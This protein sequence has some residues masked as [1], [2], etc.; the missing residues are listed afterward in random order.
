MHASACRRWS[1]VNRST[2]QYYIVSFLVPHKLWV[3]ELMGTNT[4]DDGL[5]ILME[6]TYECS[7]VYRNHTLHQ[8]KTNRFIRVIHISHDDGAFSHIRYALCYSI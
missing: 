4:F 7:L 3:A 5:C 6:F 2:V 1:L 8:S